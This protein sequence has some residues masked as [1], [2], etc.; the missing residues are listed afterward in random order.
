M[1]LTVNA[2]DGRYTSVHGIQAAYISGCTVTMNV[3]DIG[4]DVYGI[5]GLDTYT[6]CVQSS[7]VHLD[8]APQ[9]SAYIQVQ[10]I[11]TSRVYDCEVQA[12]LSWSQDKEA[13]VYGINADYVQMS[14]VSMSCV[15]SLARNVN[16]TGIYNAEACVD[17][18]VTAQ[19]IPCTGVSGTEYVVD[20]R[21]D[22]TDAIYGDS[23]GVSAVT[24]LLNT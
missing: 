4:G 2:A 17:C 20:C 23:I 9:Q 14:D 24:Y 3:S 1:D 18:N 5:H 12:T 16:A 15:P 22:I 11:D 6:G 21:I 8:I 19:G 7:S 10:C 13:D